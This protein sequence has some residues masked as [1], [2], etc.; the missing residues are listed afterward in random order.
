[1]CAEF[2]VGEGGTSQ[3]YRGCLAD[4]RE[5]AVKILKYSDEV[6]KEFVSEI[7]IVS[8]LNHKNVISL[9]GFC[10][11]NDDLLLVYEYMQRGSLEE[12]LHGVFHVFTSLEFFSLC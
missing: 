1:V 9:I 5:L 10:F 8:S 3:V 6:L 2:I 12:M 11:K 4:G 7:E